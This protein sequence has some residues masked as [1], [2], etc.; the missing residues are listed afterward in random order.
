MS[1][2]CLV[3]DCRK[4]KWCIIKGDKLDC[5]YGD[6]L[7]LGKPEL[8]KYLEPVKEAE[9]SPLMPEERKP[10]PEKEDERI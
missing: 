3:E 4:C 5:N 2:M 6:R 9:P 7:G 10:E 1:I 8:G